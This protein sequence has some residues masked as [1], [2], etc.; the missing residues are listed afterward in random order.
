MQATPS[1]LTCYALRL[2]PGQEIRSSLVQ[3]AKE[4][5]LKSAFVLTCCG[6]VQR[7]TLRMAKVNGKEEGT[8]PEAQEGTR[9]CKTTKELLQAQGSELVEHPHRKVTTFKEYFEILSLTGTVSG[10]NGHLHVS[11]GDKDGHVVG[12]H[13]IGDMLVYTTAEVVLGECNDVAFERVFDEKTG[14][15]ELVIEKRT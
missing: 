15:D 8:Q 7:A 1:S 5:K 11:L 9:D 4:K 12:G 10:D 2:K 14:F 13:V 6:S 3:F